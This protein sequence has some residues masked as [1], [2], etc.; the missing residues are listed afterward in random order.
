[1]APKKKVA[2]HRQVRPP[3]KSKAA[4]SKSKR[5]VRESFPHTPDEEENAVK[6]RR[7]NRRDSDD[8]VERIMEKKLYP[9]YPREIIEGATAAD[10]ATPRNMI[11]KEVQ[12]HEVRGRV[13]EGHLLDQ[14]LR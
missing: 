12:N 2:K 14:V 4:S 1:M 8:Q 6:V 13:L 10:G 5:V 9:K 7:L 11:T 3:P